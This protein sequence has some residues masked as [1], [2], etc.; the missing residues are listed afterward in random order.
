[1]TDIP[2]DVAVLDDDADFA[3][4]VARM[5]GRRGF[6]AQGHVLPATLLAAL[7]AGN[8]ACVVTDIQMGD[9]D[10]FAVARHVR[11]LAPATALVFM[12]AWPTTSHAVDAVRRHGGLDYLEKPVDEGRL[13]EAVRA[14]IDWSREAHRIAA[15][16]ASL[17]PRER[18]VFDL[19]VRGHSNKE[20]A[21]R[22][23]ISARTV[24][25]HRAAI[26]TKTRTNGLAELIALSRDGV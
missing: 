25:D 21:A 23:A 2:T 6:R 4:S 5:L 19:L 24:E 7:S 11:R 16:T 12:T 26:M 18:E 14:G 10:G 8:I 17:T 3:A 1:M 9:A 15:A 20:V 22:L 13:A